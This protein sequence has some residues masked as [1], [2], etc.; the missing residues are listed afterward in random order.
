MAAS[1]DWISLGRPNIM[2]RV[3]II[4]QQKW[5]LADW[6]F[7]RSSHPACLISSWTTSTVG[8]H[9]SVI[10][11]LGIIAMWHRSPA[12]CLYFTCRQRRPMARTVWRSIAAKFCCLSSCLC[13]I[14]PISRKYKS[15]SRNEL[16]RYTALTKSFPSTYRTNVSDQ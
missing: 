5:Y 15:R 3:S 6:L 16:R 9:A 1:F 14:L 13:V 11:H 2:Q 4:Q 12:G 8:L 10:S 7:M